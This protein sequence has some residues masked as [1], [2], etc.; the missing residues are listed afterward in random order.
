MAF[1]FI[2]GEVVVF[3]DE[4]VALHEANSFGEDVLGV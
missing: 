2:P 1:E 4:G 3:E